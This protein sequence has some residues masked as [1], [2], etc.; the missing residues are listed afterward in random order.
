MKVY[1]LNTTQF[2]PV[3]MEKAWDFFSSP[4]NLE[5]ITPSYMRFKILTNVKD[6]PV[7]EGMRIEYKVSPILGIP[8]PWVTLISEV[9]S[10]YKFKDIQLKG[11]YKLWEHTHSF[12]KVD[13]GVEMTDTLRYALPLGILG[14]LAHFI[15]VKRQVE[16]IFHYRKGVLDKLFK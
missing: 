1:S 7:Y 9:Q 10:P 15:F 13:G 16:E 4:E 6:T 14:R 3:S 12:K 5:K 2:V 11:P 8:L